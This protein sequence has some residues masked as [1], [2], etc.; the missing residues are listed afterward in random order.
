MAAAP[1]TAKVT[2][3]S[4]EKPEGQLQGV[5]DVDEQAGKEASAVG[6]KRAALMRWVESFMV[7]YIAS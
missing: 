7:V 3:C 1:M 4:Y 2:D 6:A 5:G